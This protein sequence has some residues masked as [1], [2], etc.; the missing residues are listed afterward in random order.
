MELAHFTAAMNWSRFD[1]LYARR[2]VRPN[3]T[4]ASSSAT[5]LVSLP[6]S[7]TGWT[8]AQFQAITGCSQVV[9]SSNGSRLWREQP[10]GSGLYVEPERPGI[11]ACT[12]EYLAKTHNPRG[13]SLH[14]LARTTECDRDG[15]NYPL[16]F[17]VCW[18]DPII[19]DI[20]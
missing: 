10:A 8:M 3:H 18:I 19:L 9:A 13:A 5:M 12:S 20:S 14:A 16:V 15:E 7:G 4:S 1:G 2:A 11:H 17:A 6:R